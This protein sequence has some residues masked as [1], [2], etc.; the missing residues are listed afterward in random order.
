MTKIEEQIKNDCF[1]K[2]AQKIE[3][4]DEE[5]CKWV[6]NIRINKKN[7]EEYKLCLTPGVG[8]KGHNVNLLLYT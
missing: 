5:S 3:N 8:N 2:L 7:K 1:K 4:K 6:F